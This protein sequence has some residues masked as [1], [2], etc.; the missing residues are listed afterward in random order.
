MSTIFFSF[1][2]CT[3]VVFFGISP[4]FCPGVKQIS[5]RALPQTPAVFICLLLLEMMAL[6]LKGPFLALTELAIYS[7]PLGSSYTT[8]NSMATIC[9]YHY[10]HHGH[11]PLSVLLKGKWGREIVV[12]VMFMIPTLAALFLLLPSP[13]P[14]SHGWLIMEQSCCPLICVC[15]CVTCPAWSPPSVMVNHLR[16]SN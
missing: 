1:S 15:V 3:V 16:Q 13:F 7:E 4:A 14:E 11:P 2:G 10:P 9:P 5:C 6:R 12:W 8:A